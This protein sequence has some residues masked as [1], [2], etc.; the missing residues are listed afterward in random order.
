MR[1]WI[2]TGE[3]GVDGGW[4][5]ASYQAWVLDAEDPIGAAREYVRVVTASTAEIDSRFPGPD[6]P[7]DPWEGDGR[8]VELGVMPMLPLGGFSAYSGPDNKHRA[9]AFD[10]LFDWK[11]I[12]TVRVPWE[13]DRDR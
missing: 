7:S 13:E 2:V 12:E 8:P 5:F 3:R 6:A 9:E 10:T 11:A 1:R 4:E